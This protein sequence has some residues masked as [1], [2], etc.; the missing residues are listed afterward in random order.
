MKVA[1]KLCE[2]T[3]PHIGSAGGKPQEERQTKVSC[4]ES[5]GNG[6]LETL[7]VA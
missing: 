3:W 1:V 2:G 4:T 6:I 7:E 5:E